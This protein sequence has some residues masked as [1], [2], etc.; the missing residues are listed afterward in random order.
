[1]RRFTDFK[2][3]THPWLI[4][5][6]N[7]FVYLTSLKN[8]SRLKNS[9]HCNRVFIHPDFST[10]EQEAR[11]ALVEQLKEA[12]A[13]NPT[14]RYFIRNN[15]VIDI[16]GIRNWSSVLSQIDRGVDPTRN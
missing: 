7:D 14:K 15:R 8:S 10:V 4:L 9:E 1:M 2:S 16:V 6:T 5:T 12:R 3:D 13:K 11:K